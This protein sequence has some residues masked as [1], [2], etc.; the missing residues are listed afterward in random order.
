MGDT[1]SSLSISVQDKIV[2]P[3]IDAQARSPI[4]CPPNYQLAI[5]RP[6]RGGVEVIMA[7]CIF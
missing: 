3:I 7:S 5:S 1:R 6:K 4:L 2:T